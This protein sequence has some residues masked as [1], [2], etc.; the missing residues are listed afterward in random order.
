MNRTRVW[1][2]KNAQQEIVSKLSNLS[3]VSRSGQGSSTQLPKKLNAPMRPK[4]FVV[5]ES[6]VGEGD[7]VL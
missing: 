1:F 3:V 2:N 7:I 4:K 6:K 5:G